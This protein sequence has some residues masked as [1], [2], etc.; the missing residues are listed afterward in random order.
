M[1]VSG[2]ARVIDTRQADG[3][4]TFSTAYIK[5]EPLPRIIVGEIP[6]A[7][8]DLNSNIRDLFT[9][10]YHIGKLVGLVV[11]PQ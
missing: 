4:N 3:R 7:F 8:A 1:A 11:S 2:T 6:P 9:K 10:N 5:E